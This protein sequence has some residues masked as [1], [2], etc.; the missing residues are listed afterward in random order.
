MITSKQAGEILGV[1]PRHADHL[2]KKAG[3]KIEQSTSRHGKLNH[4]LITPDELLK[5][6]D[7]PDPKRAKA[8]QLASFAALEGAFNHINSIRG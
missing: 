8:Q 7:K 5:L 2:M 6:K 1:A 4:Y 3:V